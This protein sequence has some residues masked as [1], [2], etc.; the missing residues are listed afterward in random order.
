MTQE[1]N[2]NQATE[3]AQSLEPENYEGEATSIDAQVEES[4]ETAQAKPKSKNNEDNIR[5][6]REKAERA[7]KYEQELE[8]MKAKMQQWENAFSK[9]NQSQDEDTPL[10]PDDLVEGK[11]LSRF[12]KKIKQL[13]EQYKQQYTEQRLRTEYKDFDQVVNEANL[14]ELSQQY[15]YLANTLKAPGDLY[16][17][18]ASA[19]T[20]IKN[21]GIYREDN[22]EKD[23]D[24]VHQ[25][26]QKPRPLTSVNPQEA[27]TPLSQANA[28]ANGL[29]P[30]LKKQLYKE[31]ISAARKR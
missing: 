24:R 31:M 23:R 11:H 12:E 13:E 5:I 2:D 3:H 27:D 10:N 25:N 21:M 15:P 16:D 19:Y 17:K 1:Y 9:T 4:P 20:L 7:A 8:A 28:F 30:E 29:T 22:Y 6:L 18:A 26:S 14:K